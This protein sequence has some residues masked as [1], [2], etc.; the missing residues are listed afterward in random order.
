MAYKMRKPKRFE[1]HL[2]VGN[3][4]FKDATWKRDVGEELCILGEQL[5]DG[6]DVIP[7][8]IKDVGGDIGEVNIDYEDEGEPQG[9]LEKPHCTNI[10]VCFDNASFDS[11]WKTE[12][13]NMLIEIAHAIKL[14][15]EVQ[16]HIKD[17][18]GNSVGSVKIT[19]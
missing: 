14:N 4:R 16:E 17:S 8:F 19:P 10:R 2:Y 12:F 7:H 15:N 13:A 3:N 1:V 9:I 5:M 18:N 6:L 11:C